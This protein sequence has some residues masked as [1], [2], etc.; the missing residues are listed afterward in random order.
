LN[1]EKCVFEVLV[2]KFLGFMLTARGIEAN[3]D[4]Y[5]AIIDMR[6]LKNLKEIQR[7]V[8]RLTSL[9][10]FLPKLTERIKSILRMIKKQTTD[11][12]DEQCECAFQKIKAMIASPPIMCRPVE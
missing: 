4:K 6:S 5:V 10:K 11:K 7:L 9:T 12:W 8:D 2:G 1:L 3:P